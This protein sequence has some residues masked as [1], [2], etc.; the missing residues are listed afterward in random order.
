MEEK[1]I[2]G[3]IEQDLRLQKEGGCLKPENL[4]TEWGRKMLTEP[5]RFI[6][7]DIKLRPEAIRDFRKKRVFFPDIP[8]GPQNPFNFLNVLDGARRGH[9]RMLADSLRVIEESGFMGLLEKYPCSQVGNPNVFHY[10]GYRFTGE[11]L[12]HVYF[13]GLFKKYIEKEIGEDF[14]ALDLGCFYGIFS[15]LLKKEFVKSHCV[16]VD[17]PQQ[18][19]L[20]HY[21]LALNF[22]EAKIAAYKDIAR[23]DAIDKDTIKKYDFILV[24]CHLY[25]KIAKDTLDVLTNFMSLQEMGREY[26]D[27][28]LSREPFLSARFFLTVNR[29]QSAPTYDN[30]LTILDYPLGDFRKLHF[31]TTPIVGER[32]K[33]KWLFFYTHFPYASQHFEFIGKRK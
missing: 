21:Y 30:G 12:R 1:T 27:L 31:A 26:F 16:L 5:A 3:F 32:Y 15:G 20:A 14:I 9:S 8:V 4:G 23:L 11:W 2:I 22:P 19:A 24:P 28:Y 18:L 25:D 17:L 33:R 10:K 7:A 13:L 6:E 29:Y